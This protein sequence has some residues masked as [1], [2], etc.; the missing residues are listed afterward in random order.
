[1]IEETT[2]PAATS[3]TPGTLLTRLRSLVAR[4]GL[5]QG[6]VMFA[7]TSLANALDYAYNVG[8]GRLLSA[9]GYGVLVALQAALQIVSVSLVVLTVAN[10]WLAT[11]L[12]SALKHFLRSGAQYVASLG[13]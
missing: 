8:M 5:R 13:R 3:T 11:T 9:D 7:A 2:G 1:M 12:R 6:L 10:T 4:P